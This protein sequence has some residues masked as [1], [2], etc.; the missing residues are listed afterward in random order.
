MEKIRITFADVPGAS[1]VGNEDAVMALIVK[2]TEEMDMEQFAWTLLKAKYSEN[3][4]SLAGDSS[5]NMEAIVDILEQRLHEMFEDSEAK[6]PPKALYIDNG[7]T[8]L[9]SDPTR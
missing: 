3:T 9:Y 4:G 2:L 5:L 6:K 1:I 7:K 8:R